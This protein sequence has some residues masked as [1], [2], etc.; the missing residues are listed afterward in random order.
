MASSPL[1]Y[2]VSYSG[3][4]EIVMAKLFV[5]LLG[6][7]AGFALAHLVNSTP[8][9]KKALSR[10]RATFESFIFGLR[11]SFGSEQR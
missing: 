6:V 1:P 9:G 3:G 5:A 4:K 11:D 8:E 2:Q 10:V 7:L